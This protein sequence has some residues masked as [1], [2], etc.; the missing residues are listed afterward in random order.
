MTPTNPS[1]AE[2]I[3]SAVASRYSAIGSDPLSETVIPVGRAWAE[4]LGY[5]RALLD[6]I[7]DVAVSSFT[8]IGAP[9]LVAQL[10]AGEQVLDLGCGAGLDSIVMARQVTPGGQ[11]YGV[12]LAPGMLATAGQAVA[13]TQLHNVTLLT[14]A[15]DRLPLPDAG[16]DVAVVNGLFNLA[17]DKNAVATEIARVVRPGGRLVGAEIV[18]TD[19][20]EPQDFDAESWFR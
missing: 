3:Q 8:G 13:E 15:A 10:T 20:R 1:T 2:D 4:R 5:P 14:A 18:I 17:P 7:P 12:D 19:D 11:V 16:I 6:T 9:V